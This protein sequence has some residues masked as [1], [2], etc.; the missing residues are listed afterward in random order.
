MGKRTEKM[1][2]THYL[3][4][5][6][7]AQLFLAELLLNLGSFLELMLDNVVEFAAIGTII[8][9]CSMIIIYVMEI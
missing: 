9:S 1:Y 5:H 7:L 8:V 3:N 6:A 4:M 2:F